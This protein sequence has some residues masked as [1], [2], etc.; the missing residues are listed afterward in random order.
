LENQRLSQEN[1]KIVFENK[2]ISEERKILMSQNQKLIEENNILVNVNNNLSQEKEK[3]N[4]DNK[5]TLDKNLDIE[6]SNSSKEEIKKLMIINMKLSEDNTNLANENKKLTHENQKLPR[7]SC[8]YYCNLS[9]LNDVKLQNSNL[10]NILLSQSNNKI[11]NKID[12]Q[13]I[14]VLNC[15]INSLEKEIASMKKDI[16]KEIW[17]LPMFQTDNFKEVTDKPLI[18]N[19]EIDNRKQIEILLKAFIDIFDEETIKCITF[20]QETNISK[21]IHDLS[22]FLQN[23]FYEKFNL[24]T[25]LIKLIASK[26]YSFCCHCEKIEQNTKLSKLDCGCFFC[27][28]HNLSPFDIIFHKNKKHKQ[29][30]IS[31]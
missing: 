1:T 2:K 25:F 12:D 22:S 11:V 8:A 4:E 17:D 21:I 18:E 26:R 9:L 20:N 15:K 10:I 30:L 14:K 3:S 19:L 24:Q 27:S 28:Q 7:Y 6:S 29:N 31:K 5:L 16:P 13:N 23:D